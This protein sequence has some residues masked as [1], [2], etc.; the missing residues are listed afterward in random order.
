M[1]K[2]F[3]AVAQRLDTENVVAQ[4]AIA[5]LYSSREGHEH[6]QQLKIKMEGLMEGLRSSYLEHVAHNTQKVANLEAR[7]FK[8]HSLIQKAENI[9]REEMTYNVEG[10]E[11]AQA[12]TR[13]DLFYVTEGAAQWWGRSENAAVTIH[14][15]TTHH[16]SEMNHHRLVEQTLR[17]KLQSQSSMSHNNYDEER[18]RTKVYNIEEEANQQMMRDQTRIAH[19]ESAQDLRA[20]LMNEEVYAGTQRR[21]LQEQVAQ[22]EHELTEAITAA[23]TL[24]GGLSGA[25]SS[26]I[27]PQTE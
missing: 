9:F 8:A 16:H 1:S 7:S 6:K 20:R 18:V 12:K 27:S 13:Q 2:Y 10:V 17:Q 14:K 22:R 19:L 3:D 15:M 21:Q 4:N 26:A 24:Q 25:R 11:A 23:Q 5:E